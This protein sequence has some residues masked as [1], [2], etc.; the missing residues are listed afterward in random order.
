M[1]RGAGVA[2]PAR[3]ETHRPRQVRVRGRPEARDLV[4]T[5]LKTYLALLALFLYLADLFL[6]RVRLYEPR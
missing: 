6:R 1:G 3:P 2:R 4:S 5:E